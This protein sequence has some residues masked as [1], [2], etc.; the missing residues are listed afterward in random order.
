VPR[1]GAAVRLN[2]VGRR[3]PHQAKLKLQPEF[4]SSSVF[5]VGDPREEQMHTKF[6]QAPLVQHC[7]ILVVE[8]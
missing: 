3:L 6:R 5:L 1:I 4:L 8:H 7:A 2:R